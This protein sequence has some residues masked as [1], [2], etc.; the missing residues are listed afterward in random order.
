MM[1]MMMMYW[2]IMVLI[3]SFDTCRYGPDGIPGVIPRNATLN[4]EVE[5]LACGEKSTS[6]AGAKGC[7]LC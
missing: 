6:P 4:F 2:G 5:L 7:A 1:M 3:G